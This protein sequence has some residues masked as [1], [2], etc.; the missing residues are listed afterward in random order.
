VAER[1]TA[2]LESSGPGRVPVARR[3]RRTVALL[4]DYMTFFG[5]GYEAQV[6]DAFHQ[7]C[8]ELDLDLM[9]PDRVD[10]VVILS[11]SLS[12]YGGV[13]SIQKLVE[14]LPPMPIVSFGLP[15]PGL[16]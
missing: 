16:P 3:K 5:G 14:R 4:S 6:R 13:P 15:V 9:L 7:K 10:G 11:S 2:E 12:S 1:L 8:R